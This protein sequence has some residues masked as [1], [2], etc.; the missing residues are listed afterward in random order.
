MPTVYGEVVST[1][2][3]TPQL[4]RVR[5]GGPGL[6]GFAAPAGTDA[7][8]NAQF[9]PDGAAYAVP[10]DDEA[11][12]DLPRD[13]RPYP[14]RYTVRH[15]DDEQRVLTL[16]FVVH[17]DVGRA[18]R[19]AQRAQVGDRLQLRGPAGSWSPAPEADSHLLVGDE[20]ALPAVAASLAAVPAGRPVTA[21]LEVEDAGGE[22]PLDSPG[23]LTVR[24][25]HRAGA[26][27]PVEDLLVAAVAAIDPLP[28]SVSAFVHG[29]AVAT[30][31]VRRLLL[32]R[33]LVD[34][35]LLSCSPYWR[36]G[37]D[38]EQWR[39]VKAAWTREVAADV[40]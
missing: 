16:D 21:V 39:S 25:V 13:E 14:R 12:R 10:F 33:G 31:A 22:V 28:G 4:V 24:W 3:L 26:D 5:L 37:M 2:V 29:E 8:V 20:S 30:R 18:G 35:D 6:E 7:Y 32:E 17:G 11:V 27:G 23:D 34:R 36:R 1:E 38:D 15:W 9:L 40:P 19:W